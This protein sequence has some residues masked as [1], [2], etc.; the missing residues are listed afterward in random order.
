L[1]EQYRVVAGAGC[2]RAGKGVGGG[3]RVTVDDSPVGCKR[4]KVWPV[5]PPIAI[6]CTPPPGMLKS[7]S[8]P[9]SAFAWVMAQGSEPMLPSSFG[10]VTT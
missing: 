10:L 9:G 5:D 2:V 8:L 1:D 4:R 6:V 7:I 3:L